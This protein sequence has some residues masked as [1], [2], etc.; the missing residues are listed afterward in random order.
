VTLVPRRA[1]GGRPDEQWSEALT[2]RINSHALDHLSHLG[3]FFRTVGSRSGADTFH[4][5]KAFWI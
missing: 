4:I 3:C 1:I 2:G 5:S